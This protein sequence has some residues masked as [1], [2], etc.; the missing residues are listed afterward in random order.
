MSITYF[1]CIHHNSFITDK[2]CSYKIQ[3]NRLFYSITES[4]FFIAFYANA[5]MLKQTLCKTNPLLLVFRKFGR[6]LEGQRRNCLSSECRCVTNENY[7]GL[8]QGKIYIF[9]GLV[10]YAHKRACA[11]FGQKLLFCARFKRHV[12]A[13]I[14][15][16]I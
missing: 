13:Q 3:M 9:S 15:F 10:F 8:K 14:A 5:D 16:N 7:S 12:D 1:L 2:W 11:M 6:K 4:L